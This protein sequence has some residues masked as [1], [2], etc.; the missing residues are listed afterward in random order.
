MH[1]LTVYQ[2]EI[3]EYIHTDFEL[4]LLDNDCGFSEGPLWNKDG[5]YLFS[6]IPNN[7]ISQIIPGKQK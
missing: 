3:K 6:D 5:Y 2:P 1:P 7:I 4:E